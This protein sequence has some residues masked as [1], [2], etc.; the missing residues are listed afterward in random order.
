MMLAFSDQK[1][2]K[3][4]AAGVKCTTLA[5]FE[6]ASSSSEQGDI[7]TS[8]DELPDVWVAE[9]WSNKQD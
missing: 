8:R 1:C 4:I 7:E 9:A 3:P 2:W 6:E 5:K